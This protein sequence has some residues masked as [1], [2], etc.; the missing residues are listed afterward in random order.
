MNDNYDNS[1]LLV[2][3][4]MVYLYKAVRLHHGASSKAEQY[5]N[6]TLLLQRYL[7]YSNVTNK[8]QTNYK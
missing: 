2:S 8:C 1:L 4:L 5:S 6:I 7:Y 3:H